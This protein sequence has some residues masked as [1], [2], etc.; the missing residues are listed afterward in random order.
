MKLLTSQ[1]L[2]VVF[3]ASKH[4]GPDDGYDGEVCQQFGGSSQ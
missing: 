2:S 4:H 1:F 3:Q